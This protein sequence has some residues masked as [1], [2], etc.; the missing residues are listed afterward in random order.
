MN[1][2]IKKI[3]NQPSA[4]KNEAWNGNNPYILEDEYN[5][6]PDE[7]DVDEPDDYATEYENWYND[8]VYDN[9]ECYPS[10]EN[11][12]ENR[13]ANHTIVDANLRIMNGPIIDLIGEDSYLYIMYLIVVEGG[14]LNHGILHH[15][16]SAEISD[17]RNMRWK[18][19]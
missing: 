10:V 7:K 6:E 15:M 12:L 8:Q 14:L 2:K 11:W 19:A 9:P 1:K 3:E 16:N 13:I 17:I 5:I 4:F 18:S